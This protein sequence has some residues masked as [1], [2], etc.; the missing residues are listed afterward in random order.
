MITGPAAAAMAKDYG[1]GRTVPNPGGGANIYID[2]ARFPQTLGMASMGAA[3][4][5]VHE[6]GHAIES[7]F[8][9][10]QAINAKYGMTGPAA[11]ESFSVFL[12][13]AYRRQ[14]LGL[15]NNDVR[16]YYKVPGDVLYNGSHLEDIWP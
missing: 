1:G 6:T 11:K 2:T 14:E 8:A 12:E 13:N 3:E 7:Y 15:P 5:F 9:S 16:M 10:A 4:V